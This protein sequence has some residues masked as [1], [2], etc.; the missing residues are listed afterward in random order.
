MTSVTWYVARSAGLV[1]YLLLST[2][3]VLGV[4]MSA[5]ARLTWPRF[6]VEEV[7]RF[8]AILTGVFLVIHGGALLLDSVVPTSL[9]QV[10]IPFS[11]SYRPFAV[12]LGVIAAELLAAV[13]LTNALRKRLPHRLWR[14]VHYLTIVVWLSATAH[15]LLAGT[16]RHDPWFVA[17]AAVATCSVSLAFLFRFTKRA[18][19]PAIAGV[20]VAAVAVAFGLA[21]TPQARSH[22]AAKVRRGVSVP[23]TYSAPVTAQIVA[24]RGDPLVSVIGSAGTAA[25]RADLLVADGGLRDSSFQLRFAT[26]ARCHGRLTTVLNSGARGSCGSHQ[27]SIEWIIDESRH[28]TGQ[29][30]LS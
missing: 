8:L 7:H 29:L 10:L 23:A 30:R 15:G 21:F 11:T 22:T 17:L 20:A 25:L 5:R 16:D 1:A 6:A 14:R 18:E 4:L 26:G 2:S 27:V 19:L 9:V 13:G 3:V 28:V 12:G 24:Q